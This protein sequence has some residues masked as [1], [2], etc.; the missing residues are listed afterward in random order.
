MVSSVEEKM[1]MTE[2]APK[3]KNDNKMTKRLGSSNGE[4]RRF[5]ISNQKIR[6]R[7]N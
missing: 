1:M 2:P 7:L 5:G 4:I 6:R 3:K